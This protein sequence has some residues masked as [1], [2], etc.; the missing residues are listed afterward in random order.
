MSLKQSSRS[1]FFIKKHFIISSKIKKEVKEE[2]NWN[3]EESFD[4]LN[5]KY[6]GNFVKIADYIKKG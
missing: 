1:L 4:Y 3:D 5:K 6:E 2:L